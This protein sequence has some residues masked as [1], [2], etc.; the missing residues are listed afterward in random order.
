M[1]SQLASSFASDTSAALPPLGRVISFSSIGVPWDLATDAL[2]AGPVCEMH[3]TTGTQ[4]VG[5]TCSHR[6][7]KC[8][9]QVETNFKSCL[10]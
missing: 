9:E 10:L 5:F 8:K 3:Y 7:H 4:V 1:D 2:G 6:L